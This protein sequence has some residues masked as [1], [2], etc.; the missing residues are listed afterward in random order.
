MP[1]G[2]SRMT[3]SASHT[4]A[5]FL[6]QSTMTHMQ[7]VQKQEE[8]ERKDS[9]PPIEP[10]LKEKAIKVELKQYFFLSAL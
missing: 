5:T 7:L 3:V 10:G 2:T 9:K 6:L 1:S 8:T 4:L